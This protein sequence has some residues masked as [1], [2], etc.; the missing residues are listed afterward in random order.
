MTE[1]PSPLSPEQI[2]QYHEEGWVLAK[3]FFSSAQAEEWRREAHA[4]FSRVQNA[5]NEGWGSG[6]KITDQPRALLHCHNPQYHSASLQQLIFSPKL[7]AAFSQLIGPNVQLHH[8]K[9]FVK[10][11]EKGAPFP[12]HQDCPF[13]PHERHTMMAAIVHFDEATEEKG[14]VRVV[15]GSH[16]LGP[17]QH[18]SDGGWHLPVDRYP[19]ESAVPCPASAGDALFFTYLTIHGSGV[20][21]SN[22][23]RTTLLIQVRDPEDRPTEITHL[24]RGQGAML[25]GIDPGADADVGVDSRSRYLTQFKEAAIGH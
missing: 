22:E 11:P 14:C 2:E 9:L 6:A 25:H 12:L 3:G 15:P 18:N 19:L 17:L 20:N 8:A 7:A 5:A 23:A 10:P 13:F 4:L 1:P 21:R 16:K 24:S